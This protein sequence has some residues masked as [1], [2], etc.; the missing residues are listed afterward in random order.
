MAEMRKRLPE[1]VFKRFVK[2]VR[3]G[4]PMSPEVSS[5]VAKALMAW[6]LSKGSTHFAHWFLPLTNASACKL[7]AFFVPK[8]VGEE[9]F[10]FS[11]SALVRGEPD[12]S[13][14]PSG[15]LRI[16][17]EARGYT[18]WDPGS[19]AFIRDGTLYIPS[20]FLSFNK[21]ALDYKTPLL[22]S[23]ESLNTVGL[24]FLKFFPKVKAK[25]IFSYAGCEQ[26][27]FLIPRDLYDRRMDL[28]LCGRTLL[29]AS[30][31]KTQQ[32]QDHYMSQIRTEVAA[33]MS[34]LD[35]ALWELGVPAKTKHNEVAP[36]QHELAPNFEPVNLA[37]DHDQ[38]TRE[39]MRDVAK[40]NGLICLLHE[41]PFG[42]ING[43]GKHNNFSIGTDTGVNFF[44]PRDYVEDDGLFLLAVAALIRAVDLHS[45]LLRMAAA[46]PGND[47]RLGGF[48]A[49]PPIISVF[50]GQAL[51]NQLS[52][53][54]MTRSASLDNIRITPS[55][56]CLDL[57]DS[58]RNRTSPFAFTGN[59]FEFRMLGSDQSVANANSILN[60]I[61][62]ESLGAFADRLEHATDIAREKRQIIQD[63]LRDHGRIIFNGDNYSKEWEV[64][65]RRRD[66]PII[67]NCVDAYGALLADWNVELFEKLEV[68]T[69]DE[70]VS[71]YDV[72]L[73]NY[74]KVTEIEARTLAHLVRAS[75]LPA[76]EGEVGRQAV[77]VNA[78]RTSG[79]RN[80]SMFEAFETLAGLHG[81]I[82]GALARLDAAMASEGG[83]TLHEH[84][85]HAR[86]KV[87]PAMVALRAP[88]DQAEA[89]IP[90]AAWPLPPCPMGV[91]VHSTALE[92]FTPVAPPR[93]ALRV[94]PR[95]KA[96]VESAQSP[97]PAA[98][99]DAQPER[100]AP[101]SI[102]EIPPPPPSMPEPPPAVSSHAPLG[103]SPE[104]LSHKSPRY[105]N[106]P[107]VLDQQKRH[108]RIT[109]FAGQVSGIPYQTQQPRVATFVEPG[110]HQ[111]PYMPA[112]HGGGLPRSLSLQTSGLRPTIVQPRVG[113][114]VSLLGPGRTYAY[115]PTR[116]SNL[117]TPVAGPFQQA[118]QVRR[119]RS[120]NG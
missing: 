95:R 61:V 104:P 60:L 46:S 86:D 45:D 37:A 72:M 19:P 51:L 14:F 81:S 32:L 70:C 71:R 6:A 11:K 50:L 73:E 111:N 113:S 23:C 21:D 89:M 27:Y 112:R 118:A 74:V 66:L 82:T 76:I 87:L 44:K 88:C 4:R 41:K 35:Q 3:N 9:D 117:I 103:P 2:T 33:Y 43:S 48:E 109:T 34:D 119:H 39:V 22:R 7:D 13:S 18:T 17:A 116:P 114:Y 47:Q 8:V 85:I 40:K 36:S 101:R 5:L 99:P 16:T 56:P 62:A 68:L 38:L 79:V 54:S 108:A 75:V 31:A 67:A 65:A 42:G 12:A 15:G 10:D 78:L 102:I 97:S 63:T 25:R 92:S 69:R 24:R 59:K 20:V 115:Q 90:L 91:T 98:A 1:S 80:R 93:A 57:D 100:L 107:G 105:A 26:E 64:E 28:K 83:K 77:A 30:A 55:L 58:D 49:P 94:S 52:G 110:I 120:T 96:A 53:H 29:G 84:A 106:P